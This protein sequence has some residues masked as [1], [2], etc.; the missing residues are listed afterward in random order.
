MATLGSVFLSHSSHDREWSRK[1]AGDLE[2]AGISVFLDQWDISQGDLL[3]SRLNDGLR[4]AS[5]GLIVWGIH[6][7][8]SPWVRAECEV[9]VH[10]AIRNDKRLISVILANV[11]LPPLLRAWVTVDFRGC[12]TEP[13]YRDRLNRLIRAL[14]GGGDALRA[15]RNTGGFGSDQRLRLEG[16]QCV[17]IQV[18]AREVAVSAAPDEQLLRVAHHGRVTGSTSSCGR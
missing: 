7:E 17:T 4:T 8:E 3:I 1:L 11:D 10:E 12:R 15:D 13:D 18:G 5:D 9:L 16:P 14:R 6:T 2:Q